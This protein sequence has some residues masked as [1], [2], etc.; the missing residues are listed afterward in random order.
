M[1][2]NTLTGEVCK[3]VPLKLIP[4]CPPPSD[5]GNK[6]N[7]PDKTI[8][9]KLAIYCIDILLESKPVTQHNNK[10]VLLGSKKA[11]HCS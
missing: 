9:F 8:P 4:G 1:K 11:N 6:V 2:Q 10:G 7:Y 5:I 3:A